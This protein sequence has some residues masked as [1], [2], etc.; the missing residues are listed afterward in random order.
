MSDGTQQII[1]AAAVLGSILYLVLRS[2]KKAG[3]GGG[4]GTSCSAKS[5]GENAESAE[6][7]KRNT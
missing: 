3:C 5:L 6:P 1:V 2:R 7:P 4:C